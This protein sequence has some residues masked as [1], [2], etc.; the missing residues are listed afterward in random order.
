MNNDTLNRRAF[1]RRSGAMTVAGT[2]A[3]WAMN[4]AAMAEAAAAASPADDYKAVVCVFLQGGNDHGNTLV[5]YDQAS[6]DTYLAARSSVAIAR[7]ALTAQVLSPISPSNP[8]PPGRQMALA[9]ALEDIKPLFDDGRM[10]VLL[11]IGPLQGP[12]TQSDYYNNRSLPPKLFSHNDQQ[13]VWQSSRPEGALAGWGGIIG[14]QGLPAAAARQAKDNLACVNLSGNAVF[15]AGENT[16]QYMV[17][18]LGVP[19]LRLMQ[20]SFFGIPSLANAFK[21]LSV[22]L[23][24]DAHWLA[25]HHAGVLRSALNTNG[26][27]RTEVDAAGSQIQ[28]LAATSEAQRLALQL[29]MVARMIEARQRLGLKRQVFFVSLGGFDHHD[30]LTA[31]H[32]VL[33]RR[34]GAALATFQANLRTLG[35]E[36]QVTTFTAS[37]FGRTMNTNGD[38]SDH[39]WGSHHFVLGGAVRGGRFYGELPDVVGGSTDIGQGRLLPTMAVDHLSAALARWMGVTDTAALARI[40]PYLSRWNGTNPLSSL[41]S[42]TV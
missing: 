17:D 22:D 12:T 14:E 19:S 5:P 33:L 41:L 32:P 29:N 28:P 25:R 3:P 8:L 23:G 6:Y 35:V 4:L 20:Q 36:N 18:P 13:A 37:D 2:I 30:G 9:P 39:G 11:N 38:G 34:V 21:A 40:A 26:L 31:S 1:L 24:A 15:V 7:G 42:T 16:S 27:L 10:A